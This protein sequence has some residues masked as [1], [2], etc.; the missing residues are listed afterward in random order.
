MPLQNDPRMYSEG[1]VAFDASPTINMYAQ[2]MAKKQ[3]ETKAKDEA[4]TQ[5]FHNVIKELNP[6][7]IRKVH[8]GGTQGQPPGIIDDINAWQQKAIANKAEIAKGGKA[9][10]DSDMEV[11]AILKRIQDAKNRDKFLLE[12]GKA[13]FEG[14]Y[15]PDEDDLKVIDKVSRSVYDKSSYKDD[16]VSDYGWG[17]LPSK[18]TP[19]D[20]SKKF[21]AWSKGMDR[22]EKIGDVLRKDPITGRAIVATTKSFAPEQENQMGLNAAND[23]AND[24]KLYKHFDKELINISEED[25][26]KFN[27]IFQSAYGT[28]EERIMSNGQKIRV[29]NYIEN[30]A[31]LAAAKTIAQARA[32]TEK[33]ERAALDWETRNQ[34][35][36]N[37]IFI[38]D[39][40]I[41][42]RQKGG[43]DG[44]GDFDIVGHYG[45]DAEKVVVKEK[46]GGGMFPKYEEKEE[47]RVPVA[48]IPDYHQKYLGEIKP[49]TDP[50]TGEQYYKVLPN[51]DWE[52]KAG[53]IKR[54]TV[55]K[56]YREAN[57]SLSKR[58]GLAGTGNNPPPPTGD[59]P[60]HTRA[61]WKAAGWTDEQI[62]Q[63]AAAGKIKVN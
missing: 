23:V 9:K 51:N 53:T 12:L 7:G 25:Y 63:A 59:I 54:A 45:K 2:L 5:Y 52:G 60:T 29:S 35:S 49:K 16:G 43:I 57:T 61:E 1:A 8:L 32:M 55:E 48:N 31:D 22:T 11:N 17:D 34:A 30:A 28:T 42:G 19:I 20:V 62:K 10:M 26:D 47:W 58:T 37:K 27:K 15:D 36:I 6:A 50:V 21:D 40:L 39:S 46:V 4:V 13:K 3:A 14:T 38:N 24:R 44:E 56:A 41:R 33:G 18:Q